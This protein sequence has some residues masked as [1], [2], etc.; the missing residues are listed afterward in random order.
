MGGITGSMVIGANGVRFIEHRDTDT[1]AL[2]R[3]FRAPDDAQPAK[4]RAERELEDRYA[5]WQ[6]WK[7]TREEAQA[8]G[9]GAAVITALTNRE[10]AAW[11][12]YAAAILEWR[13]L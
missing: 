10:N 5:D 8:R 7:A 2:L 3:R 1:N 12:D 4:V 6:R 13:S 11:T 9:L